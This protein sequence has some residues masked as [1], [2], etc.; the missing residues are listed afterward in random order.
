MLCFVEAD[1]PLIG[2]DFTI[3]NLRVLWPRKAAD[4]VATPGNVDAATAQHV[5]GILAS[6]FPPA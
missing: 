5:Y 4:R 1:W 6:S 3:A 2:G